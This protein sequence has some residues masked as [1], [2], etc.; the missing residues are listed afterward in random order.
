MKPEALKNRSCP[1]QKT[2]ACKRREAGLVHLIGRNRLDTVWLGL[3]PSKAVA[4]TNFDYL[5][6]VCLL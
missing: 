2:R 4:E 3:G 6:T 1:Q 5:L